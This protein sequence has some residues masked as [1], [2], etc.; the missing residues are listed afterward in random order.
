MACFEYKMMDEFS[1]IFA[2]ISHTYNIKC[3]EFSSWHFRFID[4]DEPMKER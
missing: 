3:K 4:N 2:F 1:E